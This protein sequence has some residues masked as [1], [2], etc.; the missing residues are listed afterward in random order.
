M[1]IIL[2]LNRDIMSNIALNLLREELLK[3]EVEIF[4]SERVGNSAYMVEEI[5]LL[6]Q[7]LPFKVLFPLLE[8]QGKPS[9]GSYYTFNQVE[10]YDDINITTPAKINNPETI[11]YI[12]HFAPDVILSI[13]YGQIFKNDVISIPKH[14]IINLHS[15]ILP[16]YKGILATFQA[17]LHGEKQIG[18]TLHYITDPTIDTGAVINQSYLPVNKD[19]SLLWHVS[20]LYKGGTDMMKA[21][22]HT[23]AIGQ[24]LKAKE[25]DLSKGKYFSL[26]TADDVER[27]RQAGYKLFDSDSYMAILGKYGKSL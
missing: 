17:M 10:Y 25:Q 14:G 4:L 23:I 6:E 19:K 3:H 7:S 2:C 13:R 24:P 12:R 1:R 27:F 5:A 26:P 15:G 9:D 18:C 20:E 22:L 21:A 8:A 16:D 11:E